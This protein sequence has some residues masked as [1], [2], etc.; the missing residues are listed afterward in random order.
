[1]APVDPPT[2][3]L[4]ISSLE[5]TAI[6]VTAMFSPKEVQIDKSVPWTKQGQSKGDQPSLQFSSADGRVMSFELIFDGNEAGTNVHT[7]FIQN[8]TKLALVQDANGS[9]FQKRPPKVVVK[10]PG[11]KLPEFQGVIE[12]VSTNY[13][14]FLPDGT[15]VRA[16][17]RVAIR[18]ASNLA[19]H[20]SIVP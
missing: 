14:M 8:L 11:G 16:T 2:Q 7:A 9:E 19:V 13:T 4:S 6:T 18:E 15:P 12:S 5:G 20:K 3:K 17:C 10:W 1:M